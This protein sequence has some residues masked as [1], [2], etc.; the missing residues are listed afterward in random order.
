MKK[1]LILIGRD[2]FTRVKTSSFILTTIL[3]VIIFVGLTF[4]PSLFELLNTKITKTSV[5]LAVVDKTGFTYLILQDTASQMSSESTIIIVEEIHVSDEEQDV[6]MLNMVLAKG[7]DG[8]LVIEPAGNSSLAFTYYAKNATSIAQNSLVQEMVNAVK[9][10]KMSADMGLGLDKIRELLSQAPL[11]IIPIQISQED[12]PV[13]EE[14]IN[15]EG[16]FIRMALAYFLLFMIYISLAMYGNM[17][18]SG[19]AEEKS[20]RIMEIMI[21]TV[22]PVQLMTGKIIGVGSLAMLQFGIWIT[23][24]LVMNAISTTGVLKSIL[25]AFTLSAIPIGLL[26]WCGVLFVLGF[27]LYATVFAAGGALVSRVEDVN[28]TTTIIILFLAAG[29]LLAYTSFL[30]PEGVLAVVCS[31][32]PFLAPMT[33]FSRI[34]LA[35][36]PFYHILI[37]LALMIGFI[38]LGIVISSRIYRVGVLM[39]GKTPRIKEILRYIKE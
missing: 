16:Y 10:V 23:I 32:I 7:K 6:N 27:L 31:F 17:V 33:M 9:V 36:P 28:Q 8:L 2:F 39:Y 26:V 29:F 37:S 15:S 1:I 11:K 38:I 13:T 12:G 35:N 5:D 30:N 34:A 19:V 21:S 25:G 3:G 24:A 20:S 14:E 18:A 22:S 4:I